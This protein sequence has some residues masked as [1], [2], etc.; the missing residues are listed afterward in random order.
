VQLPEN[1]FL[2]AV[3]RHEKQVGLWVSL[4]SPLAAEV[5]APTG[6]DWVMI[7]MEHTP[8]DYFSV[9]GQLQV[10]AATKTAPIVRPEWNNPVAVK[11]LLDLGAPGLL[12]PMINTVEEARKAVAS[13]RYPPHGIRG[14]AASTSATKFG[15]M[16]DY[17]ERVENETAVF[18][19]IESKEGLKNAV[20]ISDIPGVD[21]LF[22]GPGDIAA[23]IGKIGHPNHDDVWALIDPVAQSLI[24]KGMPIGTFVSDPA[25]ASQLY[26]AGYTFIACGSDTSLLAKNSDALLAM[27]KADIS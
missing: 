8:N 22:F 20:E 6:Y 15:R 3:R 24:K 14:V 16:K 9:M 5:I 2:S 27:I 10:F 13:T 17:V 26:K 11:R 19:Q 18:L 23:D 25:K 12:F 1:K 21:G 4:S 7:D